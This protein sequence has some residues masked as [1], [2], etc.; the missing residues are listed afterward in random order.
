MLQRFCQYITENKLFLPS[1]KILLA[2]SGGIDSVVMTDLFSKAGYVFGI[3]HCNFRLRGDESDG[4][5]AFVKRLA[6]AY[7]V[8]FFST[9]F[10]T[11]SAAHTAG[12]S[13]QMAARDLRYD[14]LN[15]L[16]IQE[17]YDF[18]ATAHHLNDI[19]ETVL[20]NLTRG[21]GIH[22]L[23]GIRMK[24]GKLIR[25]LLFATREE[26]QAY[27]EAQGLK[28]RED[29]SNESVKYYRNL[30]R[31]EVIPVLKKINPSLETTFGESSEKLLAAEAL[32]NEKVEETGKK[33]CV[34]KDEE[35]YID[36]AAL[37]MENE[38]KILFYEMLKDY[39]FSYS[40]ISN[41][42]FTRQTGKKIESATHIAVRD[43][44]HFI[45]A[46]RRPDGMKEY[47][48]EKGMKEVHIEDLS[49]ELSITGNENFVISKSSDTASLDYD[50]LQF[51]L[52]LR[53]WQPGDWLIP[54][55]LGRRKKVSDLLVDLKIPR[56][57]KDQVKVLLSGDAVV[58]VVGLRTDERFRITEETQK[59]LV[60][61]SK[62]P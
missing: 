23:A 48:V 5:E 32:F 41:L 50:K 8:P 25:P 56:H 22:G 57:H 9:G 35:L 39:G 62:K 7:Q 17:G 6:A 1:Q 10:D 44:D 51:P 2:V 11:A 43:R 53:G 12:I 33:L 46:P 26:I 4:D 40:E 15:Q 54:F 59:I 29:S 42:L 47:L 18:L 58:W 19:I 37:E 31:H 61:R 21:T 20:L 34:W 30:I 13:I 24:A 38:K 45:V 55:G 60:V 3:A 36:I 27:V 52:K 28:W 16:L 14:W 49:L